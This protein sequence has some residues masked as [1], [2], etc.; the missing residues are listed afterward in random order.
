MTTQIVYIHGLHDSLQSGE[1]QKGIL[2]REQCD[3]I[4][5]ELPMKPLEAI[6]ALQALIKSIQG[7]VGLVGH[8]LGGFYATYLSQYWGLPAVITNP[9]VRPWDSP[10]LAG[11]LWNEPDMLHDMRTDLLTL[12]KR[13]KSP[14]KLLV[15]LQKDDESL[16]YSQSAQH[17]Q[18]C[19]QIILNGGAH[20]FEGFDHWLTTVQWHLN[21][22]G[23]GH[24]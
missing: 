10:I 5:P 14:N 1:S 2:L 21:K 12:N 6:A 8:S 4:T 20:C 18:D 3:A 13:L 11:M 23:G 15:M 7:P 19:N 24:E 16:D 22:Q 17:Y 9:V